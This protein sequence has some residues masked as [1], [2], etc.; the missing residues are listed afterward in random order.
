MWHYYN[1]ICNYIYIFMNYESYLIW[2]QI[3][4]SKYIIIILGLYDLNMINR[5]QLHQNSSLPNTIISWR[6]YLE[7]WSWLNYAIDLG[8]AWGRKPLSWLNEISSL[9]ANYTFAM[10]HI[11]H[12]FSSN[13]KASLVIP[14]SSP[15]LFFMEN[16]FCWVKV[17]SDW[18][19][20]K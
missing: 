11:I 6:N 12:K 17:K 5:S 7:S 14:L 2:Y 8:G 15:P 9:D 13:Y 16:I 18:C 1:L 3:I 4:Y 20:I 19:D 10:N